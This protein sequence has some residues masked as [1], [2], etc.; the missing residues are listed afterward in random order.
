MSLSVIM[1]FITYKDI[2]LSKWW[3][4]LYFAVG[5]AQP[6]L[7]VIVAIKSDGDYRLFAKFV[8]KVLLFETISMTYQQVINQY[9][10]NSTSPLFVAL[11]AGVLLYFIWY[12]LNVKYFEKRIVDDVDNNS[13]ETEGEII[14]AFQSINYGSQPSTVITIDNIRIESN[15]NSS[16]PAT[17]QSPICYFRKCGA[18]LNDDAAFCSKCG[19]KVSDK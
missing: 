16:T 17:S 18:K 4:L 13:S 7:S 9:L 12:R 3:L 8:K 14:E 1:D 19:T 5:I 2:Y 15:V 6:V 11:I 10:S